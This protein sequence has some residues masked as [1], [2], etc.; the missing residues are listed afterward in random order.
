VLFSNGAATV[1]FDGAGTVSFEFHNGLCGRADFDALKEAVRCLYDE[2]LRS[3]ERLVLRLDA[4]ALG[5]V[6]PPFVLEWLELFR[7]L[8]D[9][10]ERILEKTVVVLRPGVVA[11]VVRKFLGTYPMARP[12]EIEVTAS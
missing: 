1:A 7:S 3:G 2:T 6:H 8:R 5:V 10:S 4:R 11:A 9:V 12:I